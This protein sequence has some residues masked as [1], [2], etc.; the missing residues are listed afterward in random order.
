MKA[1]ILVQKIDR[2]RV[3]GGK[4]VLSEVVSLTDAPDRVMELIQTYPADKYAITCTPWVQKT[5]L[6]SKALFWE[7]T[8]TP[9]YCSPSSETYWS[10]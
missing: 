6:M 2:R 8:L 7:S 4:N 1:D 10:M 5:N 3:G 9:Y